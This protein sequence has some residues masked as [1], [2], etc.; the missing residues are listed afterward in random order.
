MARE[1]ERQVD[2]GDP[3]ADVTHLMGYEPDGAVLGRSRGG[4]YRLCASL[5]LE[6]PRLRACRRDLDMKDGSTWEVRGVPVECCTH[7]LENF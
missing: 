4:R 3:R 1:T 7:R 6:F 2:S 5:G